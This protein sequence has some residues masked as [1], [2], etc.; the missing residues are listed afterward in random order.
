M[1][2]KTYK[3]KST[4]PRKIKLT[5][6]KKD[7]LIALEKLVKEKIKS[8]K[9]DSVIHLSGIFVVTTKKVS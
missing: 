8:A 9:D 1:V 7:F 3:I 2:T 6:K 4:K 5:D